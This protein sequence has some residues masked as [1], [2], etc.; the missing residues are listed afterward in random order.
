[1]LIVLTAVNDLGD[2]SLLLLANDMLMLPSVLLTVVIG[3]GIVIGV[4][5]RRH[6]AED[7]EQERPGLPVAHA[8]GLHPRGR[9]HQHDGRGAEGAQGGAGGVL[10]RVQEHVRARPEG[11]GVVDGGHR[12]HVRGV[13][14]GAAGFRVRDDRA[15]AVLE[16]PA[17]A[18]GGGGQVRDRRHQGL[19]R[20]EPAGGHRLGQRAGA[21]PRGVAVPA[22]AAEERVPHLPVRV[23]E[24]L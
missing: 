1:V 15:G 21:A 13:V 12:R 16:A 19:L 18:A 14:L 20:G 9:D 4:A 3:Y 17:A 10:P 11:E 8:G 24:D 22:G 5:K 23:R 6:G 2:S 7:R